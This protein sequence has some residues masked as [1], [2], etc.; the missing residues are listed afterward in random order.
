MYLHIHAHMH[1]E[2]LKKNVMISRYT[3]RDTQEKLE[4]EK[5]RGKLYNYNLSKTFTKS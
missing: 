1:Q 3:K 4:E 5:G 2:Q